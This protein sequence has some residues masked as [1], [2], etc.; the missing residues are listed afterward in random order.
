M[1]TIRYLA[2]QEKQGTRAMYE[3]MF[4]EDSVSFVDYYYQWKTR[5]NEILVMEE[6]GML[7]V[8]LHLNP[9]TLWLN[10]HCRELPYIVAVA[11]S[12]S[13]RRKG[14]MGRVMGRALQDLERQQ[15]PF[16]FLLP[17]DPA[18][19]QGQGFVFFPSQE[20][21]GPAADKGSNRDGAFAGR[22]AL[23]SGGQRL[24]AAGVG[25]VPAGNI[26]QGT[27]GVSPEG[28]AQGAD[29]RDKCAAGAANSKR[30]FYWDRAGEG[31][32]PELASF[33]NNILKGKYHIFIKRDA[34][35]FYRLLAETEAERGGILLLKSL[36]AIGETPD[37]GA[38]GLEGDVG[39]K[40]NIHG[41]AV[42]E[43]IL[44]YGIDQQENRAEIRELLLAEDREGNPEAFTEA[45]DAED[46]KGDPEAFPEA[47][48]VEGIGGRPVTFL[49]AGS[50]GSPKSLCESAF[51]GMGIAF[52]E[53]HMMLRIASLREFVS[54]LKRE[55]P[56]CLHVKVT[57]NIIPQNC[58]CYRIELGRDGGRMQEI[59]KEDAELELEIGELAQLLLEGA[60]V[61][62]KEWV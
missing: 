38:R 48:P 34:P 17:K 9:Y 18:Y 52:S 25:A 46:K 3:E 7:Q 44:I 22:E 37:F 36:G 14:K 60:R 53:F 24:R 11:T 29:S 43:G 23:E 20:G 2:P 57:D 62:L 59:P 32:A 40:E 12:P 50:M 41:R 30:T 51:P 6:D 19:Y 45:C 56:Y 10:G 4:P 28:D 15:V 8:M 49:P 47:Y 26:A 13:C 16:A 54:V 61:S 39:T 27:G 1:E 55:T 31:D 35:Y 5:E 58:G 33:S 21:A 42:L